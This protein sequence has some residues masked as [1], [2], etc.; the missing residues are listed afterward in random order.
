MMAEIQQGRPR[1][2]PIDEAM[3]DRLGPDPEDRTEMEKLDFAYWLSLPLKSDGRLVGILGFGFSPRRGDPQRQMPYL[4][5]LA[6]R[7]ARAVATAQLIEELS[8]AESQ[9]EG[10]LGGL[11]SAITINDSTGK[12]IY[13]NQRAVDLLGAKSI[14]EV[15][16]AE[17]GELAAR[18]VITREDGSGSPVETS[19]LPGRRLL[20]GEAAP[21]L[22]TRSV[23]R[24][25]GRE[26]WIERRP[27]DLGPTRTS[28]STSSKTSPRERPGSCGSASWSRPASSC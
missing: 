16:A 15:L 17:P 24:A 19:E 3:L 4:V 27:R 28:R 9:F 23:E 25:S 10:I 13:A 20:A 8:S 2:I 11:G 14:D 21:S 18:F 26:F 12:V 6:D 7:V 22:V 5:S 1:L